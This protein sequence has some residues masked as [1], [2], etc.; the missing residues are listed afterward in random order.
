MA[1]IGTAA[2]SHELR[3]KKSVKTV[4]KDGSKNH[5]RNSSSSHQVNIAK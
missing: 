1:K 5:I 3:K 2:V 4:C